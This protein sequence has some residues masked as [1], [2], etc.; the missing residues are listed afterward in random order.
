MRQAPEARSKVETE[1]ELNYVSG[2]LSPEFYVP[3]TYNAIRANSRPTVDAHHAFQ[4]ANVAQATRCLQPAG[5]DVP[6]GRH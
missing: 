6:V 2:I 1:A 5:F 3:K 4:P